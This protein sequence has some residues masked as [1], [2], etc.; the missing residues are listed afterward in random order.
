MECKGAHRMRCD[1][2]FRHGELLNRLGQSRQK[3]DRVAAEGRM[4]LL[5]GRQSRSGGNQ[6]E[7]DFR[8]E[9]RQLCR[10]RELAPADAALSSDAA[11]VETLKLPSFRPAT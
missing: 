7:T 6:L 4:L 11:D 8:G 9:R 10:V 1:I 2:D 5:D 3:A